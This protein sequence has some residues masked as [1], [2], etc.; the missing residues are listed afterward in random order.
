LK[1]ILGLRKVDEVTFNPN[2]WLDAAAR[3]S[4][5]HEIFE[6]FYKA[7]QEQG[8]KPSVTRHQSL[9]TKIVNEVID[10]W[11]GS[12]PQANERVV[13]GETA[14]ILK[15]CLT[16]LKIE[17]ESSQHGEPLYF[18]YSF[19]IGGVLP[20]K[21]TLDS[22]SFHV[23]GRS[24]ELID[25]EMDRIILSIT[26]QEAAGDIKRISFLK[27]GVSYSIFSTHWRLKAIY[28]LKKEQSAK[29]PIFFQRK[30]GQ[31]R[32]MNGVKQTQPAR[33]DKLYWRIC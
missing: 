18:E 21:I 28:L 24:I 27:V 10:K 20:A 25:K 29:A 32:S 2:Q 33:T 12:M 6:L 4:V 11:K 17:E 15:S 30:K 31:E 23:S 5:L 13:A 14:E 1:E 3:G 19:G 7:L 26:K 16:F 9:I 8:E 22:G